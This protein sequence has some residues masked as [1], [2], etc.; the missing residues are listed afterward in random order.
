ML[1]A[2]LI[3]LNL[4]I[5][6]PVTDS[7]PLRPDH[8]APV[9]TSPVWKDKRITAAVSYAADVEVIVSMPVWSS[10]LEGPAS[11]GLLRSSQDLFLPI[12]QV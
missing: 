10:L 3:S 6:L 9:S 7:I 4:S 2:R 1:V 11:P 12:S 8:S 5:P